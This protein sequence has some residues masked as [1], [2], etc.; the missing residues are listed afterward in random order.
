MDTKTRPTY[1]LS[2]ET[3]FRS[4]VTYRLKVRGWKKG[5]LCKLKSTEAWNSLLISVETDFKIKMVLVDKEKHY[6]MIKGS[7]KEDVTILNIYRPNIGAS[8]YIRQMLSVI[9]GE[10]T[11]NNNSREL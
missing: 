6:I 3:H 5:I 1:T 4:R 9:K 8:Q 2:A 11:R 7:I 10:I